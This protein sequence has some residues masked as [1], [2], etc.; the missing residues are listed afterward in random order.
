MAGHT[1]EV[2]L[3]PESDLPPWKTVRDLSESKVSDRLTLIGGLMVDLHAKR[4]GVFMARATVDV[5]CLVD[6]QAQRNGLRAV[7]TALGLLGF[8]LQAQGLFGYRFQHA[9]GR[10]IDVMVADHLPSRMTPRLGRRPAFPAVAGAQ[11]LQRRDIYRLLFSERRMAR[12]GVPDVTGALMLKS[13]AFVADTRD[14]GRHLD[15][16]AV[17]LASAGDVSTIHFMALS[18]HDRQRLAV[19]A[20]ELSDGSHRAWASLLPRDREVGR[21]NLAL[22]DHRLEWERHR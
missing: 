16:A 13:A 1:L 2:N 4:A 11:A 15:D 7:E 5:D 18:A 9:D 21:R 19:L 14:R 12:V 8:E 10:K 20:E 3:V 22:I 6:Y 17:L